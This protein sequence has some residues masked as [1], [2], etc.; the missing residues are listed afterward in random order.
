MKC[1]SKKFLLS[2][3]LLFSMVSAM[4]SRI[5][6]GSTDIDAHNQKYKTSVFRKEL[7]YQINNYKGS[8]SQEILNF[9]KEKI[10]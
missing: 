4:E 5:M 10:L 6:N 8:S 7:V 2:L 9:L 3:P 1:F